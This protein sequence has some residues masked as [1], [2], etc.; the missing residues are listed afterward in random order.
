M[1]HA[2]VILH[3]LHALHINHTSH[4]HTSICLQVFAL[5]WI[6]HCK[7]CI[8]SFSIAYDILNTHTHTIEMHIFAYQTHTHTYAHSWVCNS[9][10]NYVLARPRPHPLSK[11][12]AYLAYKVTTGRFL[13]F[14]KSIVFA[15][16]A[17]AVAYKLLW[18]VVSGKAFNVRLVK[19][20]RTRR[21]GHVSITTVSFAWLCVGT[22]KFL[23]AQN[24][25]YLLLLYSCYIIFIITLLL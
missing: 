19:G 14:V 23:V 10:Y 20:S 7:F 15:V 11:H 12:R 9:N 4:T 5:D 22:V 16:C 17:F 24:F 8:F 13:L 18:T 1:L 2:S 21:G 6:S 25:C 3:M